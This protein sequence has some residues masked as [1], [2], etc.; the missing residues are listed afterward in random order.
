MWVGNSTLLRIMAVEI[1]TEVPSSKMVVTLQLDQT[2]SIVN[3]S[4]YEYLI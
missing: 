1:R 3:S 2:I 4:N